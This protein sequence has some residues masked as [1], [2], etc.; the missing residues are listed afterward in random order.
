MDEQT[1]AELKRLEQYLRQNNG[2]IRGLSEKMTALSAR[3]DMME[4]HR[5]NDKEKDIRMERQIEALTTLLSEFKGQFDTFNGILKGI[6]GT[7]VVFGALI[8]ATIIGVAGLLWN[9]NSDISS[10]KANVER[11]EK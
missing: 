7:W 8:I 11:I 4:A 10:L 9:F 6:K 3:V 2:A 1:S 5:E